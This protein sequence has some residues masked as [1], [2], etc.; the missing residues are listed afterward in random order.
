MN[1]I[2]KYINIFFLCSIEFVKRLEFYDYPGGNWNISLPNLPFI[3]KHPRHIPLS[4][5][6][7]LQKQN[8]KRSFIR[9]NHRTF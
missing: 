2:N 3:I 6:Y 9:W 7:Q 8:I 5:V 4:Q 1:Y